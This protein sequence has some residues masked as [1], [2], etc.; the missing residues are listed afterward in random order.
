MRGTPFGAG[1]GNRKNESVFAAARK[2]AKTLPTPS[3]HLFADDRGWSN[4]SRGDPLNKG[5]S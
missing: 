1:M 3:R 4:L 5:C 2:R